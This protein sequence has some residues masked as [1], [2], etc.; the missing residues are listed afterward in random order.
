[1]D[2]RF[3]SFTDRERDLIRMALKRFYD[4]M[5]RSVLSGIADEDSMMYEVSVLLYELLTA[6]RKDNN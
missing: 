5:T 6:N 1:M 4:D 3:S 2:S